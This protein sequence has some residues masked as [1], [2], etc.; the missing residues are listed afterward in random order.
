MIPFLKLSHFRSNPNT[1]IIVTS[2]SNISFIQLWLSIPC[3]HT[4]LYPGRLLSS[5][6]L[7][8]CSELYTAHRQYTTQEKSAESNCQEDQIMELIIS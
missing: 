1:R 4:H 7:H 5:M 8:I 6:R 3:L 2:Y